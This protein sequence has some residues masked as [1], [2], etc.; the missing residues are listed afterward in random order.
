[1]RCYETP[2]QWLIPKTEPTDDLSRTQCYPEVQV[3]IEN[4]DALESPGPLDLVSSGED[5][6]VSPLDHQDKAPQDGPAGGPKMGVENPDMFESPGPLDSPQVDLENPDT[7]E[8]SSPLE[9]N[10]QSDGK[11]VPM[12]VCES[13]S[14]SSLGSQ[15]SR[16][17]FGH[18][19]FM[20]LEHHPLD[21]D[22]TEV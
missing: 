9:I 5:K 8:L 17:C 14:P 22:R 11:D 4:P 20:D 1:M 10:S 3:D 19:D 7:L 18:D 12:T 21:E 2:W 6:A 16:C 15:D 13:S